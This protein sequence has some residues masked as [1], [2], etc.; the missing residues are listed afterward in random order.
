MYALL[1]LVFIAGA[2][3]RLNE[4]PVPAPAPATPSTQNG[5]ALFSTIGCG[6]CHIPSHTTGFSTFTGQSNRT[7]SP[8]SDFEL[9]SMGPNLADGITQGEAGPTEFRTAPLWGIGQRVFFLH[10]GRT[11]D[12][13]QAIEAHKS[14]HGSNASEANVVVGNFNALPVQSQQDIINF[15]RGL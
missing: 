5:Q 8:F 3:M 2:S 7:F 10:D 4:V 14:G 1:V 15:L 11:A 12:I 9:H 6:A 13:L